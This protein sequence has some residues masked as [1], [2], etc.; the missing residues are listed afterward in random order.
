MPYVMH[1]QVT[2]R[3]HL[4]SLVYF[5]QENFR[6]SYFNASVCEYL[7]EC[8]CDRVLEAHAHSLWVNA[9][10]QREE[11]CKRSTYL[12]QHEPVDAG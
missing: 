10:F 12:Q 9:H 7:N 11:E 1:L 8:R 3:R 2:S 4:T 6:S 5:P